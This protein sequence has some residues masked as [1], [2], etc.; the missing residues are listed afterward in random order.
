M[1]R[2]TRRSR[3]AGLLALALLLAGCSYA[4]EPGLFGRTPASAPADGDS[5]STP[6]G[7]AAVPVLGE[8]TWT[9]VDPR[10]IPV[11]IAVH[12]VRRVSSGTVLDWS[13]TALSGPGGTPGQ[14]IPGGL[15]LDL[16]ELQDI[17]LVDAAAGRVYRP[18]ASR[19]SSGACLCTPVRLASQDL[20]LGAPRLLQVAFPALPAS[21]RVIDVSV[22]PVP[23][24]S[25]VPVTG[26]GEISAPI[27]E[28]DLARPVEV[29]DPRA[30]TPD[31]VLGGGQQFAIEVDAVV[32]SG[33]MTSVAWTLEALSSGP[34][35]DPGLRPELTRNDAWRVT[36]LLL[37]PADG[38]GPKCLCTDPATWRD[39]LAASGRR[40]SV[41]TNFG[42]I[43][44]GVTTVDVLFPGI[45]PLRGIGITPAS[46]GA[47]RSAGA[48]RA[49]R[50][51]WTYRTK[52]PQPSWPLQ[53]WPTPA[54][55]ITKGAF[56]GRVDPI[57]P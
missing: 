19:D 6:D 35:P 24:F 46:D 10:A 40:I 48:A 49:P 4:D 56:T 14:P 43:P 20:V 21:L 34:G 36:P 57:L 5:A 50:R 55:A 7:T 8:A 13:V 3:G 26:V 9:S 38:D 30:R 18:L 39:R 15:R 32:A 28:T 23:L 51:T 47:F 53:A 27:T 52:R 37:G 29:A 33:T 44:R 1:G 2:P 31:F 22:A 11:R 42:P 41:V 25:R 16:D 12:G 45:P 17:A 54:P